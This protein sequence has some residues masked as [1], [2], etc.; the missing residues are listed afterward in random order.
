[1]PLDPALFPL[2]NALGVWKGDRVRYRN[3]SGE[4][5]GVITLI[6]LGIE[7][8]IDIEC[9]DGTQL[10]LYPA[11]GDTIEVVQTGGQF[12]EPTE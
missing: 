6:W 8:C 1:M 2:T 12:Q 4:G 5:E 10:H 7:E 9:D 3:R 11:L